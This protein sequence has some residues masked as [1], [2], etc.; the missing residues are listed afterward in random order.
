MFYDIEGED[1]N[2]LCPN[3]TTIL[4]VSVWKHVVSVTLF[5]YEQGGCVGWQGVCVDWH[6]RDLHSH[7]DRLSFR[8]FFTCHHDACRGDNLLSN[9]NPTQ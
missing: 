8:L 1:T 6:L 9:V 3:R 4:A 2:A 7:G 5:D